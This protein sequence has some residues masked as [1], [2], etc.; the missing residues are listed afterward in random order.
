MKPTH[1]QK[2]AAS[3]IGISVERYLDLKA[4][5]L[6]RCWDCKS[7]KA[8]TP[9][10][11]PKRKSCKEC[12]NIRS[13]GYYAR[14]NAQYRAKARERYQHRPPS[15]KKKTMHERLKEI[16]Q[17]VEA[18]KEA[19][20]HLEYC[21]YGDNWERECAIDSGLPEKIAEALGM[22]KE[23]MEE[24]VLEEKLEKLGL[25]DP[26]FTMMFKEIPRMTGEEKHSLIR[27]FESVLRA[28]QAK[29]KK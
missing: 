12:Y 20:D 3:R 6:R 15:R 7:W 28:R 1:H 18:L 2:V 16:Q 21:G 24:L 23:E 11:S 27:A 13:R 9:H 26:A 8:I 19:R 17:I 25:D 14:N 29:R 10:F 5:G 4:A 22:G